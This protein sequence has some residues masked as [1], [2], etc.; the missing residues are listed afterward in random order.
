[1]ND[2]Y[3]LFIATHSREFVMFCKIAIV[4]RAREFNV[5]FNI[6]E[7][8]VLILTIFRGLLTHPKITYCIPSLGIAQY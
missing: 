6:E 7:E 1:M 4:K 2:V 3:V 5:I 8:G